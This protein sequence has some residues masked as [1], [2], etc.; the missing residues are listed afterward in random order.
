MPTY[1]FECE[2]CEHKFEQ[3]QSFNDEPLKDCPACKAPALRR[4]FGI[5]FMVVKGEAKTLIQQAERNSAK[6]GRQECQERELR[7]KEEVESKLKSQNKPAPT[8][9]APWWRN[10][11]VPGLI[12][13]DK[14]LTT[15]QVQKYQKELQGMG[16]N[17][18]INKEAE[19]QDRKDK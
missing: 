2:K 5:P 14:M 12:K 17:V 7:N 19:G 1:D 15:S 3:W 8:G 6:L 4:L 16:C 10:G 11:S 13:S 18:N 9:E